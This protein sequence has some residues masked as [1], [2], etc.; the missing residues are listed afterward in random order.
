M[1]RPARGLD[2][3][4]KTLFR[5]IAHLV[6]VGQAKPLF[7]LVWFIPFGTTAEAWGAATELGPDRA[8]NARLTLEPGSMAWS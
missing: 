5:A 7:L 6:R 8:G 4:R 3:F 1:A 2:I